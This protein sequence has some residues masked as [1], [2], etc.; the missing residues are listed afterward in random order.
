M[1]SLAE[2]LLLGLGSGVACL[3]SCGTIL[4]PCMSVE[5]RR[6][7]DHARVFAVFM[8]G[9]LLGYLGFGILAWAGGWALSR[10]PGAA[11]WFYAI[12]DLALAIALGAYALPFL[13]PARK[14]SCGRPLAVRLQQHTQ[15]WAPLFL[16]LLT[17]LNLCPP[18]LAALVRVGSGRSLLQALL[19]FLVFF[20]GTLP[21]TLPFLGIGALKRLPGLPQVA[22]FL[23]LLL[24]AYYAYLGIL[25]LL[26]RLAHGH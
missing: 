17:G 3:T 24:A 4:L 8:A 9:R 11:G 22:R 18:F 15:A 20:L 26:G 6:F 5:P 25:L 21:W 16:G 7:A 12:T 1:M 10:T 23:L 14:G 19:F 2:P 13:R